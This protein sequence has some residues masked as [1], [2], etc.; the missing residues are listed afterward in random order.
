MSIQPAK[1]NFPLQRRATWRYYVE[2]LD[3]SNNPID[4]TGASIYSQ[5]W[6]KERETKYADFSIE[7]IDRSLGRFYWILSADSSELLP[8]ECFY[9]LL[10]VDSLSSPYYLLEGLV[11]VSEGYTTS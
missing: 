2:L 11:F 10:L 3:E 8:F 7:Y 5:I 9:D 1:W 4:L 6:D